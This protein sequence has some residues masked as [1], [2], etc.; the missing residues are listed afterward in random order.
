MDNQSTLEQSVL[1]KRVCV[2]NLLALLGKN[3]NIIGVAKFSF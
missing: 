2:I 3:K 1:K